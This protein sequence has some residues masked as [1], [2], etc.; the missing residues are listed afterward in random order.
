MILVVIS[1]VTGTFALYVINKV[2]GSYFN[3]MMET[4]QF[5][6]MNNADFR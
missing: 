1:I 3:I 4:L 6:A 5:Y 2:R